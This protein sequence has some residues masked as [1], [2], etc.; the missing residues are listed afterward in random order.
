M[1]REAETDVLE[2]WADQETIRDAPREAADWDNGTMAL[3]MSGNPFSAREFVWDAMQHLMKPT[4]RG[5]LEMSL[6]GDY[7]AFL[8]MRYA[9]A[10][11]AGW[12]ALNKFIKGNL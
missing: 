2:K 4:S 9:A 7:A 6:D 12:E 3:V 8:L 11:C 5:T 10:D 1:A